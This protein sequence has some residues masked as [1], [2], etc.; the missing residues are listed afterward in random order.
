MRDI[1]TSFDYRTR[2]YLL[3]CRDRAD[4]RDGTARYTNSLDPVAASGHGTRALLHSVGRPAHIWTRPEATCS[5]L[6]GTVAVYLRNGH[7]VTDR[8]VLD[9]PGHPNK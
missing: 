8:N 5:I 7:D 1:R 2:D 3:R 6:A 4:P 9:S